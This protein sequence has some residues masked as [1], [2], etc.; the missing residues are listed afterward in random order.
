MVPSDATSPNRQIAEQAF[1]DK[2]NLKNSIYI[3]GDKNKRSEE[4][5]PEESGG[6]PVNGY[7][8][9]E[10]YQAE[11]KKMRMLEEQMA[12]SYIVETPD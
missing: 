1:D 7:M 3:E 5:K 2:D 10:R 9:V 8:D 11:R 4:T 6:Q 12:Q